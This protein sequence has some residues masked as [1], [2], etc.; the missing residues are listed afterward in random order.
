ML[1]EAVEERLPA[2]EAEGTAG[3]D[4]E[5]GWFEELEAADLLSWLLS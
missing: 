3:C 2:A 1:E 5:G 4:W